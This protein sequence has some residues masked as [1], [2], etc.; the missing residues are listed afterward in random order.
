[1]DGPGVEGNWR[2]QDRFLT[3]QPIVHT[4]DYPD[5]MAGGMNKRGSFGSMADRVARGRKNRETSHSAP[6]LKHCWVTDRHGRLPG[7]LLEWERRQDGFYGRVVHAV[8]DERGE[9][10]VAEEW[11]PAELLEPV[12]DARPEGGSA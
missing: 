9:W 10:I 6:R 4:F 2:R 11:L 3:R 5:G 8:L 7:L 1:M 12:H